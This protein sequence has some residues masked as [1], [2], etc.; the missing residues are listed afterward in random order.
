MSPP[1]NERIR[2]G[3]PKSFAGAGLNN[4]ADCLPSIYG[5]VMEKG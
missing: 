3:W 5:P 2:H 1:Y 4:L